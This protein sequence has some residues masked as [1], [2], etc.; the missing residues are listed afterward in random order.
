MFRAAPIVASWQFHDIGA[1]MT[2]A[3]V[4]RHARGGISGLVDGGRRGK[5][6]GLVAVHGAHLFLCLPNTTRLVC[7][8]SKEHARSVG[9][10]S[11]KSGPFWLPRGRV[12][13]GYRARTNPIW[14]PSKD[15]SFLDA[16][17]GCD[18]GQGRRRLGCW[19]LT[20]L[21]GCRARAGDLSCRARRGQ[22]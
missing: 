17:Q 9:L 6:T 4:F 18:V 22:G 2:E 8:P 1:A 20:S 19:S 7:L 21:C 13:F 16:G 15:G 11:R 12:R 10:L 3:S 5:N 14:W